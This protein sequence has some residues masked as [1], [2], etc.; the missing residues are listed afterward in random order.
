MR[1]LEYVELYPMSHEDVLA[2]FARDEVSCATA[3]VSASLHD[4]TGFAEQV[5]RLGAANP[6]KIVRG[7]AMIAISHLARLHRDTDSVTRLL[8]EIETGLLDNDPEVRGKAQ[9][10]LE[11]IEVFVPDLINEVLRLRTIKDPGC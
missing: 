9:E 6:S 7:A 5:V 8:K 3:I 11:D 2:S 1:R 4:E 10:T